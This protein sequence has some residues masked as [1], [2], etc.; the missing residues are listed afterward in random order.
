MKSLACL[1]SLTACLNL[2]AQ[3]PVRLS[4]EDGSIVRCVSS[5]PSLFIITNYGELTIP[6][7]DVRSIKFGL[8]PTPAEAK[9][10]ELAFRHLGSSVFRD[11][12][13]A[14]K[15]LRSLG[16]LSL[17]GL[18]R[19][20]KSS[21]ADVR[22][23]AIQIIAA[24]VE[25]DGR[26]ALDYDIVIASEFTVK[27]RIKGE[28]LPFRSAMFGEFAAPLGKLE[29]LA[30]IGKTDAAIALDSKQF[31]EQWCDSGVAVEA[32]TPL[33]VRATGMV[34]LWPTGPGQYM[35][36]PRGYQTA[37]RGGQFPAGSLVGKIGDGKPF[38]IGERLSE[39][40]RESGTLFLQIIPSPWNNPSTG[41]YDV[42]VK[43][44]R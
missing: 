36:V 43:A 29:T 1:I 17:P 15:A 26:P 24:I 23:A 34:D 35:A 4:L 5:S 27:G 41:S 42:T 33:D 9:Q 12:D 20:E 19:A 10:L 14:R 44:G 6:F 21:D 40:A 8:H 32:G 31:G 25:R 13:A 39:T 16:R 37:G 18:H 38:L 30:V 2:H 28:A 7:A 11:R 3:T 22:T